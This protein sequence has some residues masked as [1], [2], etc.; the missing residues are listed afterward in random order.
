[1]LLNNVVP[2]KNR[3]LWIHALLTLKSVEVGTS[4]LLILFILPI[5]YYLFYKLQKFMIKQKHISKA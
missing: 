5:F 2:G 1:M 3:K 4:A